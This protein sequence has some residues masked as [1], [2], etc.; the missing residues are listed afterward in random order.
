[1]RLF[2]APSGPPVSGTRYLLPVERLVIALRQ[3]PAK[4]LPDVAMAVGGLLAAIAVSVISHAPRGAYLAVWLLELFLVLRAVWHAANWAVQY[5]VVTQKRL[6]L[7]SGVLGRKV[8][9]LP[10]TALQNLAFS[11][12]AGGRLF[13]YGAFTFEADGQ[14]WAV[15]DYIPY[16]DQIYLEI[17]QLLYPEEA[18]ADADPGQGSD[19]AR[20]AGPGGDDGLDFDNP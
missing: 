9:A 19:P 17:Y 14:A 4:L 8:T 15:I 11:R 3:H 16:P 6:I 1:V 13:G 20:G 18:G 5:L 12:S 7:T 2:E 10:L